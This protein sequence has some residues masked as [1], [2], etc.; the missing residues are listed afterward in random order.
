MS[1]VCSSC[2]IASFAGGRPDPSRGLCQHCIHRLLSI[3]PANRCGANYSYPPARG[4][5]HWDRDRHP[6]AR[7]E[8]QSTTEIHRPRIC[9]VLL[10]CT[11]LCHR[12]QDACGF[13]MSWSSFNADHLHL[14]AIFLSLFTKHDASPT[15]MEEAHLHRLAGIILELSSKTQSNVVT[16]P[17][18][19]SFALLRDGQVALGRFQA[20]DVDPYQS[21]RAVGS[22]LRDATLVLD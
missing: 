6:L 5:G 13:C 15:C 16:R 9:S 8:W 12:H 21:G 4:T 22:S 17:I 11:I 7:L 14:G 19:M 10:P 1:W 3:D 20:E 2:T 18:A